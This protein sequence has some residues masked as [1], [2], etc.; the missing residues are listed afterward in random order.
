[1]K[2]RSRKNGGNVI[3]SGGFGCIFNPPLLCKK[4]QKNKKGLVSKLMLKKYAKKEYTDILLYKKKLETIPNYTKYFLIDG[5]SLCQDPNELSSE[6][7]VNFNKKCS[8]LKKRNIKQNNIN[9]SLD[10][11]AFIQMPY[12]GIAVDD[13]VKKVEM[14]GVN[15]RKLNN[16]LI[17]LLKN[18]IVK[19]NEQ[20]VYHCDIKDS[21]VLVDTI[22]ET[23]SSTKIIDWGLSAIYPP[24]EKKAPL[25]KNHI[26][27]E[28]THRP[29]QFNIPFSIILFQSS[30]LKLYKSF[31]KKNPNA[32]YLKIRSFVINY[33]LFLIDKKGPGHIKNIN[34]I[35]K[36]FFK[37]ELLNVEE[38]FKD[39]LVEFEYTFYFVFEYL[40]KILFEFTRENEFHVMDYFENV[41]LKNVDVWGFVTIYI[42][43]VDYLLEVSKTR[44]LTKNEKKIIQ[45][46]KELYII[47]MEKCC[48]PVDVD[49]IITKL[50]SLDE[51][52][53]H[54][55]IKLQSLSSKKS[56]TMLNTSIFNTTMYGNPKSELNI[57]STSK[58]NTKSKTKKNFFTNIF[59]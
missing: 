42:T 6:D 22:S 12:G 8:A 45:T 16:L 11:L 27:Y 55:S 26:P 13:Y 46:I 29:F 10:K 5:F 23:I 58:S 48:K 50:K 1:M 34:S 19:M 2:N 44:V 3:A 18:G 32:D 37:G 54:T 36:H 20:G 28:L 14:S 40:S 43:F 49:E 52:F 25:V 53:S 21:N 7:L 51:L 57:K 17:D 47:L 41:F 33:V 4:T 9:Q 35:V 56:A 38:K 15:M 24:T 59:S 39:D 30:F 31:L